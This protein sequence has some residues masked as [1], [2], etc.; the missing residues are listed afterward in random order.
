[1]K[2]TGFEPH[3]IALKLPLLILRGS[4]GLLA[5]SY[6]NAE[7]FTKTGEAAAIVSGVKNFDDM[8]AATVATVS[9][10][11]EQLGLRVGMTGAQAL[12]L[13]R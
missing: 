13:I 2:L 10:A 11:G 1:M 5:C 12:E 9:R 7:T 3:H 8:A 4:K 6:L